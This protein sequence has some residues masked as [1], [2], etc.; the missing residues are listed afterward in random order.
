MTKRIRPNFTPEFRLESAQLVLDQGYS[1]KEAAEAMNV[2]KSTMDKWVRQLKDERGGMTP[3]ATPMTPD[4]LK[5][6][7]L[8]KKI[9]RIEMEKEIPKKSN[10]SFG[11]GLIQNFI[12]VDELKAYYPVSI[13]CHVFD[14]HRSSYKYWTKRPKTQSKEQV[15]LSSEV[16]AAHRAS[17]G[18]AGAR[19]I[20]GIVTTKGVPLSRYKATNIMK[21]LGLVSCQVKKHRYKKVENEHLNIPNTLDRQFAVTEP[22]QVW[23][24][25]VTYIWSGQRWLY[26]AVVIDLFAR[27]VIGWATSGSSNTDLTGKALSMAYEVRGAPKS[28][29]FHSDQGCHYTSKQYRRLLWRYQITQSM[30]R[31]G[32]CWDNAPMERFFRSFKTEWMPTAGYRSSNEA[33]VAITEYII[34]YYNQVRPHQYNGGL[35][36]NESERRFNNEYKS[37]ANFT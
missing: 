33:K 15:L 30:S 20:A 17:S 31:R 7:E 18:S 27:K 35:T 1:V 9:K 36:P 37:V 22:N 21:Q 13:L 8:E 3:K 32:N 29:M 24:S 2:G 6:R 16:K 4:Q 25:D 34:R 12:L 26:L 11:L 10:R 14:I 28:V 23:C 5:I 19:T